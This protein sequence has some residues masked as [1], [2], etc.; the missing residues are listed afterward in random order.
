MQAMYNCKFKALQSLR[1]N[2]SKIMQSRD[3]LLILFSLLMQL[4]AFF[5]MLDKKPRGP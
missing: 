1:R 5:A 4:N 2:W 3:L